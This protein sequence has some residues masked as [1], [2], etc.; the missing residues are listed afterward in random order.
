MRE[1]IQIYLRNLG[2]EYWRWIDLDQNWI[3]WQT[4][5]LPVLNLHVLLPMFQLDCY[6]LPKK[7]IRTFDHWGPVYHIT[8]NFTVHYTSRTIM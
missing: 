3:H 5:V 4:L 8:F 6:E 2:C 1:H 7:F